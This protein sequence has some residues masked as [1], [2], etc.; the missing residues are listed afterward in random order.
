MRNN[1]KAA[2]VTETSKS[3]NMEAE[4]PHAVTM[5]RAGGSGVMQ[6]SL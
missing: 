2:N 3:V 1:L 6:G 5:R 4:G